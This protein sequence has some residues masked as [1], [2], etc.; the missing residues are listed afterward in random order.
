MEAHK[1]SVDLDVNPDGLSAP[2]Q[3]AMAR[4][5]DKVPIVWGKDVLAVSQGNFATRLH[6]RQ[7]QA[8]TLRLA[9]QLHSKEPSTVTGA[10]SDK[11]AKPERENKYR[12]GDQSVTEEAGCLR[13]AV[14]GAHLGQLRT[15]NHCKW[16][17]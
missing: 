12:P 16:R 4:R 15:A 3:S 2:F 17:T 8:E 1:T 13:R 11:L 6:D 9:D 14:D 5:F 7:A 10:D